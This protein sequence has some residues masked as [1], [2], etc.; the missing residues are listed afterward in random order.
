M[1]TVVVI[2]A[3]WGDEG[4]GRVTDYLAQKANVVVR[5][6]GGNNAGHTV[7]VG[8]K[9]YK[10]HLIPSGIINHEK[11]SVIGNGVVVDPG[12]LLEELDYLVK[13]G[14]DVSSLRIS[15]RAHIIMPYHKELDALS[16]ENL[17]NDKIGTTKKGIGPCYMDKAERIGLRICDLMDPQ[18]FEEKARKNIRLKNDI[19]V[20]IYGAKPL[21]EDTIIREYLGYAERI[22]PYVTDAEN[23]VYHAIK[24]GENVLFEG[25]QGAL[26]DLDHGTY[27]FVTSSHPVAGGVCIGAG[28]GPTYIDQVVG[29]VKAY[30][31]RVGAGPFPTELL[32]EVGDEI[33]IKG[34][35]FGTTT[36]R[37][38]RC[39]W[40]DTV[41]L[42]Y[43]VMLS[44]LTHL[45]VNHLDTLSEFETVKI[46]TGYRLNGE[47]IDRIPADLNVL[48]K[49]E[50]I[51]EELPGWEKKFDHVETFEDLPINAQ[52]YL[53]RVS[54]LT[55]TPI[56]FVSFGPRRDQAVKLVELF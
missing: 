29:V 55:G 24:G 51:Y 56:A 49:C 30:T 40:L 43:S 44:G 28:I 1:S 32:D 26:L 31:T 9:Q 41:V 50:P 38:R 4:K 12:A 34:H 46:C 20:K 42:R 11:I 54:E 3:Q 36:G 7:E 10:L 37:P 17:G 22:R 48:A 8:D 21:D 13:E 35:E 6:Q 39:G 14:L 52:K 47:I 5:Y 2:G 45:A 18:A 15:E 16:E 53:N 33:R 27:P 23:L 19:L 25:A